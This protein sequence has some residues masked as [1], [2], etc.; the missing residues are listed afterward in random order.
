MQATPPEAEHGERRVAVR[1]SPFDRRSLTRD[2]PPRRIQLRRQADVLELPALA[3]RPKRSLATWL[4][5]NRDLGAIASANG[6][7]PSSL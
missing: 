7:G 2:A 5:G 6:S 4:A 3:A 1:R